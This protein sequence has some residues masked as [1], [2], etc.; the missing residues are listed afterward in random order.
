MTYRIPYSY[1]QELKDEVEQRLAAIHRIY[2]ADALDQGQGRTVGLI[3]GT[4]GKFLVRLGTRLEQ[5]S[6]STERVG[7]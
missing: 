5:P 6:R 7:S 2:R 4:I 3:F 1:E